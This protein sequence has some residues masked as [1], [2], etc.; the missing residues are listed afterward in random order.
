[1]RRVK[2]F[3]IYFSSKMT[4]FLKNEKGKIVE[5]WLKGAQLSRHDP[6]YE[7][8]IRNA[9]QTIKLIHSY[10]TG[11]NRDEVIQLT[12]KI[13]KERIVAGVDISEFVDNINLGREIVNHVITQSHEFHDSDK[14]QAITAIDELFDFYMFSAV[15]EYSVLKDQVIKEKSQFIQEMHMERL[16]ILGQVAKSFAH[17]IRNPLTTIKG[18]LNLMEKRFAD[19]AESSTYFSIIDQEMTN[20]EQKVNQFLYLTNIRAL[21][22]HMTLIDLSTI[23]RQVIS[24]LDVRFKEE[25]ISLELDI[26]PSCNVFGVKE[27]LKQVVLNIL[28][29]AIEVLAR[30]DA[31]RKICVSLKRQS[32]NII[33]TLSNNGDAIPSYMLENIFEPF[34]TTKQLATGLGLSVCKQIVEKHDGT[35]NA[36]SEEGQTSF[37]VKFQEASYRITG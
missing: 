9:N 33:L 2:G 8:I 23:T 16:T 13:A 4:I 25:N 6:F 3:D 37:V 34:I 10:F 18:F 15:K 7:E 22:D 29:N 19:D 12:R 26:S 24:F 20:L 11:P 28:S 30:K 27:Q 36:V 1:M 14:V 32:G 17:E 31:N 5:Q 21:D 35:I